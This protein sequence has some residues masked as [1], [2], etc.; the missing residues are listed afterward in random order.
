MSLNDFD[1]VDLDGWSVTKILQSRA[2]N[3]QRK[4]IFPPRADQPGLLGRAAAALAALSPRAL[5][6]QTAID[7]RKSP[8]RSWIIG[9]DERPWRSPSEPGR[10]PHRAR[11]APIRS[12]RTY[13]APVSVTA[14]LKADR[15]EC[16][17]MT[18]FNAETRIGDV[19]SI[20]LRARI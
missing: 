6:A 12:K 5:V 13:S 3:P 20:Y 7:V 1:V 9:E 4:L 8:A 10:G 11:L 2:D 19:R 16:F 15:K 17:E 14:E 18:L